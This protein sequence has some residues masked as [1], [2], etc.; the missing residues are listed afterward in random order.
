MSCNLFEGNTYKYALT[1]I[2]I[3][4]RCK[5][6]RALRAKKS[7]EVAFASE[8]IYKKGVVF[9]YPKTFQRDNGPEFKN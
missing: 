2:D 9:K 8:A 3:A 7:S 4:S 5:V 6:A 1:G